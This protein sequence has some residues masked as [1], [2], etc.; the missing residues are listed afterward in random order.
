MTVNEGAQLLMEMGARAGDH[1]LSNRLGVGLARAGSEDATVKAD[2]LF[3]LKEYDFGGPLHIL[4]VPA[5]LHFMEAKAL[6]ALAGAPPDIL[7][8]AK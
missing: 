7:Q 8:G 1:Y 4:V 6:V 3:R 5:N 2:L